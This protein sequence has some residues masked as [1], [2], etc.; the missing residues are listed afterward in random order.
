MRIQ[1]ELPMKSKLALLAACMSAL[2]GLAH[3]ET[4]YL[5]A[6]KMVD[7]VAGKVIDKPAIVIKDDRIVSV[8]TAGSLA[9]PAG[10][11]TIDLGSETIL[12][13][14]IDMHTHVTSN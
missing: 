1:Q 11:R 3:A 14:L 7:P 5:T 9:A 2:A 8:G 12:P 10:A 4:I 6:A 13:G